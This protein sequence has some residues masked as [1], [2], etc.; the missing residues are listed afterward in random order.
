MQ[1]LA[2]A[3]DTSTAAGAAASSREI[4]RCDPGVPICSDALPGTCIADA[5]IRPARSETGS[6]GAG[7]QA[8]IALD[9]VGD[10]FAVTAGVDAQGDVRLRWILPDV[11]VAW[12]QRAR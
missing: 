12:N 1:V 9:R 7:I 6:G 3:I 4:R 5:F 8:G 10:C 2:P 11:Q